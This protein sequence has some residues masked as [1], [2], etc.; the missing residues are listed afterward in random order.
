MEQLLCSERNRL[1]LTFDGGRGN[2]LR[3][4]RVSAVPGCCRLKSILVMDHLTDLY[5]YRRSN[6]LEALR[7]V[8]GHQ[9]VGVLTRANHLDYR[10]RTAPILFPNWSTV[11]FARIR[12]KSINDY[13]AGRFE[14][15]LR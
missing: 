15:E 10:K 14:P 2:A 6:F 8:G 13:A 12:R 1:S 5:A 4:L 3:T 11:R 7:G 9:A